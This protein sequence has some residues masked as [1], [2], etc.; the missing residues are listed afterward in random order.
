MKAAVTEMF[1]KHLM[2]SA[3]KPRLQSNRGPG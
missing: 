1:G 2:T 3:F